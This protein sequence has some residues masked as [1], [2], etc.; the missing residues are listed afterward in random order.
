MKII[1]KFAAF[2]KFRAYIH[3]VETEISGFGRVE[4]DGDNLIITDV[5]I[6]PQIVSGSHTVM[7]ARALAA[8]WDELIVAGE[9]IGKWKLWWHSHV[10]MAALFS[11]TDHAT[12]EE[13]DTEMP[14]ENWMLSIVSNK[15]G[16][17]L[18]RVDIF[19]PIRCTINDIPWDLDIVGEENVE[20]DV[21]Q[22]V[23]EKVKLF[24]DKGKEEKKE[25]VISWFGP[26]RALPPMI[27]DG[28]ILT[29]EQ[30]LEIFRKTGAWPV[31]SAPLI[32]IEDGQIVLDT[33]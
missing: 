20:I 5:R 29:Y 19:Q 15:M 24:V 1:F 3:S 30:R 12:I 9:D 17:S 21:Q 6:F 11:S 23:G 10:N 26:K 28:K 16:K 32:P 7:D 31:L 4:K 13:F 33:K 25:E 8:F 18:C 27:Q 2:K 22:E 14:E